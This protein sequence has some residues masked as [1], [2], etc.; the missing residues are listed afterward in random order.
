MK[1]RY[2]E[3]IFQSLFIIIANLSQKYFVSDLDLISH[4]IFIQQILFVAI[5][6]EKNMNRANITQVASSYFYASKITL[7][8]YM[9]FELFIITKFDKETMPVNFSPGKAP[10]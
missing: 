4:T 6:I 2:Y 5:L 9:Y 10:I 8:K 1:E 7:I 3:Y